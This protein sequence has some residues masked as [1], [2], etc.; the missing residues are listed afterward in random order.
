[1]SL[2]YAH[3]LDALAEQVNR[4]EHPEITGRQLLSWFGAARR[5]VRVVEWIRRELERR[6]IRT[7]PDFNEAWVDLP[8]VVRKTKSAP[9][10]GA[11]EPTHAAEA[12]PDP[13]HRIGRLS[14]ANQAI[15]SVQPNT[16]VE[17]AATLMMLKD[18]SQL[19]VMRNE[20]DCKGAVT[21]DSIGIAAA[22]GRPRATVDD[23]L[24]TVEEVRWDDG[25]LDTIPKIVSR[26]FVLV[27]GPDR[28]LQGIVTVSDL[29]LQFRSLSEPFLLLGQ[30]EKLVRVL[31]SRNFSVDEL[32]AARDPADSARTITTVAD[33]SF[34]ELVR[35]LEPTEVWSRLGVTFHRGAF[36]TELRQ[37]KAIRNDVMHFDPDPLDDADLEL[38][39]KFAAFLE[40]AVH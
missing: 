13:V 34:G 5:G 4:G 18:F 23:C 8:L 27:R 31:V 19:P 33:L 26:N 1:M 12:V 32:R 35:L 16:S 7:E 37:A 21:W 15:V 9:T 2:D 40:K 39:R 3:Q 11:T 22:L 10:T 20:R 38:L 25:L 6:Q 28:R 30:I 17:E 36:L 14:A 24:Q 29:S